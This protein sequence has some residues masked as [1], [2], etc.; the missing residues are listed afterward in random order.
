M[1]ERD[2]QTDGRT[3]RIALAITTFCIVSGRA[4]R[5]VRKVKH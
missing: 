3:D 1:P 5:T 2:G 4:V